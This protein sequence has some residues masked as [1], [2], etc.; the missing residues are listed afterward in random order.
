MD[1]CGM[2]FWMPLWWLSP[3][4][5]LPI[6]EL[7]NIGH[8]PSVV[9]SSSSL[10]SSSAWPQIIQW[11][12]W[13]CRLENADD[14]PR[15]HPISSNDWKNQLRSQI[16]NNSKLE[17]WSVLNFR[18]YYFFLTGIR[19]QTSG[20]WG[21][22]LSDKTQSNGCFPISIIQAC[23]G[24]EAPCSALEF[25]RNNHQDM[26]LSHL[27]N[28]GPQQKVQDLSRRTSASKSNLVTSS[29]F[30]CFSTTEVRPLGKHRS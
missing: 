5:C 22:I 26:Y 30:W 3:F 29:V 14:D 28:A 23:I 12:S 25:L 2:V 6:F 4:A 8:T 17:N 18:L 10:P 7:C 19:K 9:P 15:H 16:L 24:S 20:F 27:N 1:I 21:Y 11:I 13:C